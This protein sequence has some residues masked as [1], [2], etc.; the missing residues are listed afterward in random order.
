MLLSS[1]KAIEQRHHDLETNL[2][3]N[4]GASSDEFDA[5]EK[6]LDCTIPAE[7]RYLWEWRNGERTESFLWY[8]RFLSID[9]ALEQYNLLRSNEWGALW[10]TNWIPLFEFQEEWYGVE[11]SKT[12]TTAT[13]VISFF[14]ETGATVS[15]TNLT[16]YMGT[17]AAAM[18]REA[19]TWDG[20]FWEADTYHL[21]K[22][23][24]EYNPNTEFPY[25]VASEEE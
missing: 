2:L 5:V 22:I 16:S 6:A 3:L 11:C 24:A 25:Y 14:I 8:H 13:P 21:S 9:D 18:L 4:K 23:H 20:S 7:L 15:Y 10:R 1:I 19:V 17:M 12:A